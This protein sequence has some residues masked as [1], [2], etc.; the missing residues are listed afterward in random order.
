MSR[1]A[2]L[3]LIQVLFCSGTSFAG[4][5]ATAG[6]GGNVCKGGGV[7]KCQQMCKDLTAAL[8]EDC[9]KDTMNQFK[10][11]LQQGAI[12]DADGGKWCPN[13][14]SADPESVAVGLVAGV[15]LGESD[16]SSTVPGPAAGT[17]GEKP[18]GYCQ[19][20]QS[21]VQPYPCC[22]GVTQAQLASD[23]N[24]EGK[25][26]MGE[27]LHNVVKDKVWAEGETGKGGKGAAAFN[28]S[29]ASSKP[30]LK[31]KAIS[32]TADACANGGP[33][34]PGQMSTK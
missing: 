9:L 15:A 13:E 29:C 25:C 22:K 31:D 8:K 20:N 2:V 19:L 5:A 18:V 26:G 10:S 28:Q 6:A 12:K 33:S 7:G 4:P 3:I 16:C 23:G 30:A 17:N 34:G 21:S 24:V 1:L 27:V 14:T 32:S 11:D